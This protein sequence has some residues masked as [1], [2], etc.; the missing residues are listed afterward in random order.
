MLMKKTAVITGA[1][2]GMGKEFVRQVIEKVPSIDEIWIIARRKEVLEEIKNE[3]SGK[4]INVFSMD[5]KEP[6]SW[7][8]YESLLKGKKPQIALLI[9][10]AGYGK[11]GQASEIPW[12]EQTGMVRLNCEAL[13]AMTQLTIPYMQQGGRILQLASAS[14]FLPQPGFNVYAASKAYVLSYSRA[15][16]RELKKQEISVTAVCPGPVETEFFLRAE[17]QKKTP[18]YKQI[19]RAS[20]EKVV[21]KALRDGWK[22][23]EVSVYGSAIKAMRAASKVVPHRLILKGFRS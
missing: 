7:K 8:E 21:A 20:K 2:S 10:A 1:S 9:N 18:V 17:E 23:K 6:S 15:L 4:T 14:A 12:S 5:L 22:R 3:Y 13:T 16:N 19:F 11:I